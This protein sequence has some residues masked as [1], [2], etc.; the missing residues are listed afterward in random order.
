MDCR[1][2][3]GVI[4]AHTLTRRRYAIRQYGHKLVDPN[5]DVYKCR[6]VLERVTGQ[7]SIND[8]IVA[9]LPSQLDDWAL[10][11]RIVGEH[12]RAR[13]GDVAYS[14]WM[15]LEG[16]TMAKEEHIQRKELEAS[17]PRHKLVARKK[18]TS[19]T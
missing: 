7:R 9:P 15:F 3:L 18:L 11:N 8:I 5:Q 14:E 13:Q 16:Q 17:F 12:I 10:Y 19:Q 1:L 2:I 6:L 4:E